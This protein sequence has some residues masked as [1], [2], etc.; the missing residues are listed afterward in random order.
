MLPFFPLHATAYPSSLSCRRA[1]ADRRRQAAFVAVRRELQDDEPDGRQDGVEHVH[2][3]I[4]VVIV[5]RQRELIDGNS[6]LL[7]TPQAEQRGREMRTVVA[8][9]CSFT[10]REV[11]CNEKA[12]IICCVDCALI[13]RRLL[14]CFQVCSASLDCSANIISD[15]LFCSST[16]FEPRRHDWQK[17]LHVI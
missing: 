13:Q 3:A 12:L 10:P 14:E 7:T 11:S 17:Y 16:P 15:H 9:L 6:D 4:S 8:S 5:R 2:R 1:P